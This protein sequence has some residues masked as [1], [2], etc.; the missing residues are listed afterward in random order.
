MI[1]LN[2]LTA[3][4]LALGGLWLTPGA[5]LAQTNLLA[6][7]SFE[8][9][10]A[11]PS[12]WEA[13]TY[14]GCTLK[15]VTDQAHTGV[16]SVFI[17][18]T[19]EGATNFP[20]YAYRASNVQAGELYAA[21]VWARTKGMVSAWGASI[22]LEFMH[23]T[24]R[25][26]YCSGEQT[27]GGDNDWTRLTVEG[28]VPEAATQMI[29]TIGTHGVGQVWFDDA[30]LI[31]TAAPD[32]FAGDRAALRVRPGQVISENFRGFGA[33]GNFMLTRGFNTSKGVNDADR[34]LVLDRAAAMRLRVVRTLFDYSWWEPAEGVHTP[35]SEGLKD[36]LIWF[37]ALKDAGTEVMIHPWGDSFAYPDWMRDGN[38]R[39]PKPEKREAM[40]RS[41]AEYLAF[42][43]HDKKMINVRYVCLM[44][45]PDNDDHRAVPPEEFLRLSGLLARELQKR[46]LDR[47]VMLIGPD[48]SSAPVNTQ[49]LFFRKTIGPGM[50]LFQATSSHTYAHKDPRLLG[51]WIAGRRDAMRLTARKSPLPI[52]ITEF[53]TL[54][55]TW[56]N[57]DNETYAHGLFLANFG[58]EA[59]RG[60]AS[61]ALVW[62]LF[63]TYY[64]ADL[65]QGY[66]LWRYKDAGWAPRPGYYSW[67]LLT[68]H[69]EPGCQ[70]VAVETPPAA[71]DLRAVAFL[72]PDRRLTVL[73]ANNYKRPLQLTLESGLTQDLTVRRYDYTRAALPGG[74]AIFKASTKFTWSAAEPAGVTIE[75]E[76][77]MLLAG[78]R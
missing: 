54:G 18:V 73:V 78:E 31:R 16:A 39:L 68:R 1:S 67:S 35:D 48:D 46:G 64:T 58:I 37:Q 10:G 65:K 75:P 56:T 9:G 6:N 7:P 13:W 74:E 55:G 60:G 32:A 21:A 51:S 2:H 57:P 3:L 52:F 33:D 72:A 49:S 41:L 42:L 76:S 12:A 71:A 50:D 26:P 62:I 23:G 59:A 29:V 30:T 20:L 47:D 69:V 15:R 25:L 36:E 38:H 14:P 28:Y 53:N 11:Q 8:G 70:V 63:D 19:S 27:G 61:L 22:S 17:G 5:A 44:N 24:T 45:E 4:R 77:F 43:R 40:V 34:K 66:G